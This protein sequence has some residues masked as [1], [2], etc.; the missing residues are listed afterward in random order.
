[1]SKENPITIGAFT[2]E[3]I[4]TKFKDEK[5]EQKITLRELWREIGRYAIDLDNNTESIVLSLGQVNDLIEGVLDIDQNANASLY[6]A[7]IEGVK[8]AY[9]QMQELDLDWKVIQ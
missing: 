4:L 9:N 1:M 8:N 2:L 3:Q 6:L 5:Q 7:A